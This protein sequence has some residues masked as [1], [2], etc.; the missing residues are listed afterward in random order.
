MPMLT[1][2]GAC[3]RQSQHALPLT[4]EATR[5]SSAAR[6]RGKRRSMHRAGELRVGVLPAVCAHGELRRAAVE[7]GL[8]ARQARNRRVAPQPA[9]Q[10]TQ[11]Q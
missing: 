5:M 9:R 11:V 8:Q 6:R 3:R 2:P 10:D 7:P 1:H 4:E